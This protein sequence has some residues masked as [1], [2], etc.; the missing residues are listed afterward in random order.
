VKKVLVINPVTGASLGETSG[1]YFKELAADSGMQ[2]DNAVLT[3]G[4]ASV[5]TLFDEAFSGPGVIELV[6]ANRDRYDGI[7]VNCF[8][9][10]AVE[11]ARELVEIPVVGPAEASML[12]ATTLGHKFSVIS[13]FKNTG[14]WV[15]RQARALGLESRMASAIGVEIPVLQLNSDPEGTSREIIAAARMAIERDGAEVIVLGCTGMALLAESIRKELG[16]PVVEPAAAAL[17]TLQML[18]DL[19]LRHSKVGVYARVE[20]C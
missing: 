9:D 15:E 5:E 6:I 3:T 14:P 1:R 7:V 10:P 19:G 13:T 20:E 8:A 18:F 4:P 11:A 17:K 12:L 16:V 2:I